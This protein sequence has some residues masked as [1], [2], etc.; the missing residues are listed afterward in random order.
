MLLSLVRE[1][2]STSLESCWYRLGPS[3]CKVKGRKKTN[4]AQLRVQHRSQLS[5]LAPLLLGRSFNSG[6]GDDLNLGGSDGD[7][8]S[9]GGGDDLSFG[10][11]DPFLASW[12]SRDVE[13]GEHSGSDLSRTKKERK[14]QQDVEN[15]VDGRT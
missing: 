10:S 13:V 3:R 11:S 7:F 1:R 12:S 8:R 15:K 9:Y 4:E 5:L 6:H 2:K 14:S